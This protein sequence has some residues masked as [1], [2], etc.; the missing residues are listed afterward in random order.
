ML[1]GLKSHPV[2][3]HFECE[4]LQQHFEHKVCIF[5][6]KTNFDWITKE[7]LFA[8]KFVSSLSLAFVGMK[9]LLLAQSILATKTKTVASK[10][11]LSHQEVHARG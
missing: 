6:S 3:H 8:T 9:N 11:Y 4:R 5:A 1:E 2:H 7:D 10:Y